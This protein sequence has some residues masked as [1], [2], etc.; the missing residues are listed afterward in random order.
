MPKEIG[1]TVSS[2]D[3][4]D[5]DDVVVVRWMKFLHCGRDLRKGRKKFA[6]VEEMRKKRRYMGKGRKKSAKGYLKTNS[7]RRIV[8]R[9]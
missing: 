8:Q 1:I 6:K 4:E 2:K 7:Q 5:D 3:D 9:L